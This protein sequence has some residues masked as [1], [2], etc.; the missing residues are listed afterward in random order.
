MEYL[1]RRSKK[2]DCRDIQKVITKTWQHT[3]KGIM[4]EKFLN[5]LSENEEFRIKNSCESF[6]DIDNNQFVLIINDKIVGFINVGVTEDTNYENCGEIFAIYILESYQ[7]KGFGKKLIDIGVQELKKLGF[8]K[9][10][11][12]CIDGNPSNQFYKQL[13]GKFVGTRTITKGGDVLIENIYYFDM[14]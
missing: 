9:Y 4:N 2:E 14:N 13:G 12:G 5:D 8:N 3:Y 1:V 10:I 6:S 11:I 7:R